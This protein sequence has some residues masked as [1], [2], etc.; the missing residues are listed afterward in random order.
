LL[1]YFA[2][3]ANKRYAGEPEDRITLPAWQNIIGKSFLPV[4]P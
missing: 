3:T 4:N 2:A 1:F